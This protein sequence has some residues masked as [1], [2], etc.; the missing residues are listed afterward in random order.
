[1]RVMRASRCWCTPLVWCAVAAVPATSWAQQVPVADGAAA[2]AIRQEMAALRAEFE[3]RLSALEARLSAVS[4]G[5]VPAPALPVYGGASASSKVFNPDV[6]VIGN[7]VGS[8]GE[9]SINPS[10]G[11]ELRETEITLQAIVDP[12]ARADVFLSFG[13]EGAS[14]EEGFVTFPTLPGGL[15]VKVGRMRA[16]FGRMNTQHPHALPW[17]D[18]PLVTANLVGGEEGI[19]DAGISVARLIP[20]PWVFLEATGQ[21]FSGSGGDVFRASERRD[22]SVVGRVRGYQDITESTNLDLGASY[23]RGHNG[24]GIVNDV[25]LGR[26]RTELFGF[27]AALRWK[28]LQRS[29]YRS[30]IG[31]VEGVLSRR[32]QPNG[33]QRAVGFFASGDYQIGRRWF[34]GARFDRSERAD[35]PAARDTGRSLVLTYWPSEFNEIR[36]QFRRTRYAEGVTANEFLLQFQFSIG[37]HGAHVF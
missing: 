31:R 21:V 29:I 24:S 19:A 3:A 14:V 27:D 16:S 20:N 10:P 35:D 18:R 7:F 30:F 26:F 5:A 1:M 11:L 34:T 33:R 28:P 6:A 37:A 12:Y 4:A 22:V 23:A 15:L 8:A 25:D 17:A 36:G 13:P 9:N 32:D 2:Q